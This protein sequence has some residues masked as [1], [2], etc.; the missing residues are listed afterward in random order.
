M[1]LEGVECVADDVIPFGAIS[2][3]KN[4]E[5]QFLEMLQCLVGGVPEA[6]V[7]LKKDALPPAVAGD[8]DAVLCTVV[9]NAEDVKVSH[10][11]AVLTLVFKDDDLQSRAWRNIEV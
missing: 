1:L 7:F 5:S 10:G 9:L 2:F 6:I 4:V 11:R 8:A 3:A